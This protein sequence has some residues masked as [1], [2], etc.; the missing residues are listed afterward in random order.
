MHDDR[1]PVLPA[2]GDVGLPRLAGDDTCSHS[3][4]RR[5][6]DGLSR[7]LLGM[8]A[9]ELVGRPAV[10]DLGLTVARDD[11]PLQICEH[12]GHAEAVERLGVER[13]ELS[14]LLSSATTPRAG[15]LRL[16]RW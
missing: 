2:D 12:D 6:V 8:T 16:S 1:G 5:L 13:R 10:E 3:S 14:D 4:P 15:R 9:H 7:Q 11:T